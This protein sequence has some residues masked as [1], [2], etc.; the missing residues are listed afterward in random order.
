M[1]SFVWSR[2][3]CCPR[4]FELL[5]AIA[6]SD[7]CCWMMFWMTMSQ[8]AVTAHSSKTKSP[9]SL[10]GKHCK[11]GIQFHLPFSNR[12]PGTQEWKKHDWE[13]KKA[14]EIETYRGE[15]GGKREGHR[16]EAESRR[17]WMHEVALTGSRRRKKGGEGRGDF[18]SLHS[19]PFPLWR[20]SGYLL[21]PLLSLWNGREMGS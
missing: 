10:K 8:G 13:G 11:G 7:R 6:D 15:I 18:R 21:R 2:Y 20:C 4:C 3:V 1:Y 12:P 19:L 16:R 9:T 5:R 17:K 14:K